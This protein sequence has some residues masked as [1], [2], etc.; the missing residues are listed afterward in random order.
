[1]ILKTIIQQ[2]DSLNIDGDTH[3]RI[4]NITH[5]SRYA[6][7]HDIF[8]AIRGEKVDG[9]RFAPTLQ[10]AAVIAD[11]PVDVATGVTTIMVPDA[12][13]AL[14]QAAAALYNQPSKEMFVV[15]LTGTNGKSTTAGILEHIF[16]H[17]H[18]PV[19]IIGTIGHRLFGKD[20]TTQDGR[21]TPEASTLQKL[22]RN[23]KDQGCKVVV[24]EASSIGIAWNRVDGIRFSAACFTN[25]SRDHL[26]FHDSMETYLAAK[27]RLF[28]ELVD[29]HSVCIFNAEDLACAETA[30]VGKKW[31]FSP[32][33]KTTDLYVQNVSQDLS[34][35]RC[36]V[37][38]PYGSYHMKSP[39]IGNHNIDNMLC[40][41]GVALSYGLSLSQIAA[42]IQTLPPV[43]GRLER[44]RASIPIFVDYAHSP[45]ALE[46]VLKTLRALCT[47]RL[48]TVFGCG[49]DRDRG[50]RPIM[51]KIAEIHS[52]ICIVT[53][54]NPRT[55]APQSIINDILAGMTNRHRHFV[56]REEGIAFAIS[57]AQ[58]NDVVLIAGKGHETYQ[59]INGVKNPFDDR[60]VASKYA[61]QE[62]NHAV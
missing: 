23:W 24:M 5:D 48:I 21:T 45:D 13:K 15:G 57:Q 26:D 18:V 20:I 3:R 11:A 33:K 35:I 25:F 28:A 46:H 17:N 55:E 49:G 40:A 12:R 54:D 51:G 16:H 22:L 47:G 29:Q 52:D 58:P 10:V 60:L 36:E 62:G 27:R 1:M 31:L 50:K 53:S 56:S 8:V 37:H 19:G 61:N 42:A 39:L 30:T 43:P 2:I 32:R 44:V 7:D 14:A 41:I 4:E 38:T 59:E 6:T 34:G 9:R